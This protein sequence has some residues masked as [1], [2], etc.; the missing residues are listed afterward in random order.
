M[1]SEDT[2]LESVTLRIANLEIAISVRV[3]EPGIYSR[4]SLGLHFLPQSVL[5]RA[6]LQVLQH[7]HQ[8]VVLLVP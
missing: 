6:P 5:L 2:D 3:V 8:L 7:P 1:Q 4:E